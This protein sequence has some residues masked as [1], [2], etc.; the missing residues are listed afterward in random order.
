MKHQPATETTY[1]RERNGYMLTVRQMNNGK[2]DAKLENLTTGE[3][4]V[5]GGWATRISALQYV[6]HMYNFRNI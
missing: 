1:I 3:K 2:F 6:Q 5:C 4:R